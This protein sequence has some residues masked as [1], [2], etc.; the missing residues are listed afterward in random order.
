MT[1]LQLEYFLR[2]ATLQS[3]SKAADELNISQSSL[4]TMMGKLEDEL[5]YPLFERSG[6]NITITRYGQIV[7]K[8]SYILLNK[9]D[10]IQLEFDELQGKH[11]TRAISVG[12]TDSNYYEGWILELMKQY[13]EMK[14]NLL[15]MSKEAICKNLQTGNLD[16]GISDDI[17]YY[18]QMNA[19]LLFSQPYQLLV[20]RDHPLAAKGKISVEDLVKEPFISLPPSHK[21]RM[22]DNLSA[23]LHFCPN[24]VFE[25]SPN[26]MLAMFQARMGSILTCAHNRRQ[27]VELLPE[28]YTMLNIE[29]ISTR[30]EM[31]LIWSKHRY[32][33][34]WARIFQKYVFDYYHV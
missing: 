14:I 4:S 8:Y 25:G 30:Y 13:P 16:F 34:K 28:Q 18:E 31:Y 22:I 26:S 21:E 17:D 3:I 24:I 20:F 1:L 19:Q 23:E 5:G 11:N 2:V 27:W 6:R 32:L 7:E 33:S 12:V 10:D 15:Q 29:G 9:V